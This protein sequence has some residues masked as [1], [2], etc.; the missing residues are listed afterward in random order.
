MTAS[1]TGRKRCVCGQYK[2]P[3][4]NGTM[5]RHTAPDLSRP[6]IPMNRVRTRCHGSGKFSPSTATWRAANG[7]RVPQIALGQPKVRGGHRADKRNAGLKARYRR[8]AAGG[9]GTP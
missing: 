4:A 3:L 7:K 8:N 5:P 2:T 9:Y 6:C 1:I